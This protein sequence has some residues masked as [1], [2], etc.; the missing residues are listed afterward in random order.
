MICKDVSIE[1]VYHSLIP[2]R[3]RYARLHYIGCG[4]VYN[5]NYYKQYLKEQFFI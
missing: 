5:I 2:L 1:L 4:K 3:L